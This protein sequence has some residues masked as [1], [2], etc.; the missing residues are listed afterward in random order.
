MGRGSQAFLQAYDANVAR[1]N[2][3]AVGA[4]PVAQAVLSFMESR[5]SW[6]GTPSELL[7]HLEEAAQHLRIDTR[8]RGWPKN[9][10]W[11][12]R[13]LREVEPN[14]RALGLEVVLGRPGP[15]QPLSLGVHLL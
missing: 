5:D 1:Q 13:R 9:P 15:N 7:G 2:E 8:D 4:S 11:L 14:L 3:A 10:N 12:T 6:Q